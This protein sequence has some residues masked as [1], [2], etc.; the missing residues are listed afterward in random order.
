MI[1]SFPLVATTCSVQLPVQRSWRPAQALVTTPGGIWY[2]RTL[3]S[4]ESCE[5]K[6]QFAGL[7]WAE[8]QTLRDFHREMAGAHHCFRFCDPM[9]NLL[10]WSED[11]TQSVWSAS[12]GLAVALN[13]NPLPGVAQGLRVVNTSTGEAVA[14]QVIGCSP[15]FAYSFAVN[16]RSSTNS[17]LGLLIGG[18][19]SD[20]QLTTQWQLYRTSAAPGGG[21]DQVT[22]AI[23]IPFGGEAELTCIEADFGDVMPEYKR[24]EGRT[25]LFTKARF[26]DDALAL[27]SSEKDVF[28]AEVTVV[29]N[30]QE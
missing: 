27:S 10:A 30:A 1:P 2:L 21:V 3:P 11:L 16:A 19:R 29:A 5:W 28:S 4:G 8:A 15:N 26:K 7:T 14:S 23:A 24:S 18:A 25:G 13:E 17:T 22:F 6:L 20:V 12:S 9:R